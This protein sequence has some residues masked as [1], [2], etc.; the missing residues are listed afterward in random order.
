VSRSF[1][2]MVLAMN[3]SYH[4]A[5][6]FP[7][8]MNP[9]FSAGLA[10]APKG[11]HETALGETQ[12]WMSM[13]GQA[14]KGRHEVTPLQGERIMRTSFPG[15]YPGLS[16]SA[17]SGLACPH[18]PSHEPRLR[19]GGRLACRRGGRPAPRIPRFMVPIRVHFLEN[20]P[21]H[22]PCL[23]SG[24]VPPHGIPDSSSHDILIP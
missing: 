23:H 5:N 14:L 4:S 12:G 18:N 22:E 7:S 16:P 2:K 8:R 15:L 1:L 9:G 20:V 17:P 24:G 19:S 13:K 10:S 11:L 6:S 3:R 21:L